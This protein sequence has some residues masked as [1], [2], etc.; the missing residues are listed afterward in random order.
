MKKFKTESQ[1]LLDLMINSIYTNKEIFLREL[2]SNASDAIDKLYFKSLTDSSI[3]IQKDD[4]SIYV[5][6]DA[7]GRIITVSDNGIGMTKEELDLNL[8]TIAH[9]DSMS[10]K[11]DAGEDQGDA[12]DIIGQFGVGFYSAFMVAKH[13]RVV[14]RAYGSEEAYEWESDGVEGYSIRKSERLSHGT[15]VILELKDDTADETYSR[16]LNE[17]QLEEL[18]RKYSNYVRYPIR[19]KITTMR[20][21][22]RPADAP[23]DYEP[24]YEEMKEIA[25]INSMI[26]IW[27]RQKSE[28]PQE[29][30]NDFYKATFHEFTDPVRTIVVHAE[31]GMEYDA[32]LFIPGAQPNDIYTRDFKKGLSLYSSNVLIMD[33]CEDLL[34]DYFNFVVGVVDSQDLTLNISRETL[35]QDKQLRAIARKLE[36]KIRSEL[37]DLRDNDREAYEKVFKNF[38]RS[39]KYCIYSSYGRDKD[40]LADLLIFYSVQQQKMITF[41]EYIAAMPP[42]QE[43]I[44]YAAGD[45]EDRL[46]KLPVVKTVL[47]RGFDVLLCTDKVDDFCLTML[48]EYQE[49]EIKNVSSGDLG[50]ETEEEK[51][52]AEAAEKDNE[53]LFTV[54]KDTLGDRVT[55][56]TVSTRL[57]DTPACLSAAGPVSFEMERVLAANPGGSDVKSERVLEI[58]VEHPVFAAM[59]EALEG[60]D[61]DKVELYTNLLYNQALLVEGLPI[62]DPVAFT[63]A[64]TQLMV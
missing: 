46:A 3:E 35:Q 57:T 30:Y 51:T 21:K 14:S 43:A 25:T 17:Y 60:G 63:Q 38:G 50:L 6:Y 16:F 34:P 9:S 28:V 62:D 55:K 19:M 41:D 22:A 40:T 2:I 31:G 44:F 23:D 37:C 29:D 5:A 64:V 47:D 24:Q 7:S 11:D 20:E 18:I 4:L 10:F 26:P 49:K 32:L 56:V 39:M 36:K 53:T 61:T 33:K 8:G 59:K 42:D 48:H 12:I 45:S 27:K 58:N 1:K 52:A 15:D 13:V 54:I